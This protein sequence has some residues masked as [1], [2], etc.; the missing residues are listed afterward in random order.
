MILSPKSNSSETL[1][2]KRKSN[3]IGFLR[4][5]QLEY[6]RMEQRFEFAKRR[7]NRLTCYEWRVDLRGNLEFI[8]NFDASSFVSFLW[9]SDISHN[10]LL[11]APKNLV[12][13]CQIRI[14]Y[15]NYKQQSMCIV[16]Y[17]KKICALGYLVYNSKF[18]LVVHP[19]TMVFSSKY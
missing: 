19:C 14:I 1:P 7:N 12:P 17:P 13:T 3:S 9:G 10:R 5:L 18:S 6:W 15:Y 4:H 11:T 8:Y 16:L 2:T